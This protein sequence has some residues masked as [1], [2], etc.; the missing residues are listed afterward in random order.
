MTEIKERLAIQ[1]LLSL[2][3]RA[4]D[5]LDQSLLQY[6]Y[7]EDSSVDYG[8]FKGP[9]LQFVGLVI[10]ALREQYAITRHVLSNTLVQID[11]TLARAESLVDAAHLLL[12]E[13]EEMLFAGRYLD[14]LEKRDDG[15]RIQ[16]RQVVVDWCRTR[17][18]SNDRDSDSF[19][20]MA[21]GGHAPEDPLYP[22][23]NNAR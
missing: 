12:S 16:H 1:D 23:L 17:T 18:L 2:H 14:V 4:L 10:P 13:T 3:S 21:G 8:T 9:A 20:G 7:R 5:R 19:A 15:W 6:C 11:G 22:F